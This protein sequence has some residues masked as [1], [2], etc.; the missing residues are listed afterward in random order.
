MS[1]VLRVTRLHGLLGA[2]VNGDGDDGQDADVPAG[3]T[4]GVRDYTSF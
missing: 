1:G 2:H 3:R 4:D